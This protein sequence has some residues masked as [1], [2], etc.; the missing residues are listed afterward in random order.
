M[1][2]IGERGAGLSGGQKQR[3]AIARALIKRPKVPILDEATSALDPVTAPE[4]ENIL[5]SLKGSVSILMITH[6]SGA[7][8]ADTLVE[9]RTSHENSN[10]TT[11]KTS[12]ALVKV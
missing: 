2:E 7:S 6:A 12:P 9:L 4:L 10:S 8:F 3:F 5:K 11:D 1:T